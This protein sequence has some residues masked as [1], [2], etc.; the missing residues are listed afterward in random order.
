MYV[1]RQQYVQPLRRQRQHDGGLEQGRV[2]HLQQAQP[3]PAG[4]LPISQ[5]HGIR[6][7]GRRNETACD[8]L[9]RHAAV[10]GR[11][12][13]HP[14]A[15]HRHHH[16]LLW[17]PAVRERRAVAAARRWRLRHLHQRHAALL[18]PFERPPWQ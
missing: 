3:P 10:R 18:F 16:R 5:E 12:V 17:Q 11:A 1:F 9:H 6:P 2:P 8:A 14:T 4:C 13:G 7:R 15:A